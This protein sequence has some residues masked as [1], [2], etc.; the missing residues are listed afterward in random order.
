MV[1]RPSFSAASDGAPRWFA[2]A[3][4]GVAVAAFASS[5]RLA[6]D[7]ILG[8]QAPFLMH[9]PAVV[10]ASW[11]GG[12]AGGVGAAAAG[13]FFADYLLIEPRYTLA[14]YTPNHA[15]GAPAA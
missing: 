1:G 12:L 3:V 14:F 15:G 4:F 11:L 2:G 13:A 6:S 8:N 7:P 10:V 9:I 5:V